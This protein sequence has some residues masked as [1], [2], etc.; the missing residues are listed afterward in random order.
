MAVLIERH[1]G[2]AFLKLLHQ[3]GI[4]IFRLGVADIAPYLLHVGF[5]RLYFL[6]DG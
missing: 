4:I 6:G 1:C 2:V 5:L 3:L